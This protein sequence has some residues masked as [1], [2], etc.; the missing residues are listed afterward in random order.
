MSNLKRN[1]DLNTWEKA[2]WYL[3]M[4]VNT[5]RYGGIGKES[6]KLKI[7]IQEVKD[8]T[9]QGNNDLDFLKTTVSKL[10]CTL[11]RKGTKRYQQFNV[12]SKELQ[13]YFV[14]IEDIKMF[15]CT[16][17]YILLPTNE[18]IEAVPA[19]E[20]VDIA[21]KYA[22][23]ELDKRKEKALAN[24]IR[25][26]DV[27]TEEFCLNRE[28][29][30]LNSLVKNMKESIKENITGMPLEEVDKI[31]NGS[32]QEFERRVGQKR[33]QRAGSDL[34]SATSY[35]LQYF[36]FQIADGPMHFNAGIEVDN[37]IKDS[38]G[39]YIGISL[40]RTLRERWKQTHTT[41]SVLTSFKIKYIIHLI[42]NDQD[43]SDAKIA[44]MGASRHLFFVADSSPVLRDLKTDVM[45][46]KY[47]HPM[48]Q[49]I[50][51]LREFT[52]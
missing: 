49:L 7:L 52:K 10:I 45:L 33:K 17:E 30:I 43:L 26:W 40:K 46:G 14:S 36:N 3:R 25:E 32:C 38:R 13:R 34:E 21:K 39:R 22:K 41:E 1:T 5:D 24:L 9:E 2:Y 47:L 4:L 11:S 50:S 12:L 48:S 29:E 31:I 27:I 16:V 35:I 23:K 18:A 28:R 37:W 42:N 20:A 8:K 51:K 19:S 6:D 44:E 15:L